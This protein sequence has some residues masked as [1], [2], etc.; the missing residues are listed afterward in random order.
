EW[1][2]VKELIRQLGPADP[3]Y[4]ETEVLVKLSDV[5]AK[6]KQASN[7]QNYLWSALHNHALNLIQ[8]SFHP[9]TIPIDPVETLASDEMTDFIRETALPEKSTDPDQTLA[10]QGALAEFSPRLLRLWRTLILCD[11]NQLAAAKRLHKHPNTIAYGV[12]QIRHI[13]TRHGFS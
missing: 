10:L 12:Q 13:L 4:L 11:G 5:K 3:D 9:K 7:W 6:K 2:L 1:S 8:R